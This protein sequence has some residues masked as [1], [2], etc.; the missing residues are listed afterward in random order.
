MPKSRNNPKDH[1][2]V[3]EE[4]NNKL[5]YFYTVKYYSEM[6][7]SKILMDATWIDLKNIMLSER[8]QT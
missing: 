2:V 8:S 7:S 3:N 4:T 6:K 5:W 1:Q